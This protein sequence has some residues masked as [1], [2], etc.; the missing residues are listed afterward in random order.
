MTIRLSFATLVPAVFAFCLAPVLHADEAGDKQ[1][2]R[3]V[4]ID[5]ITLAVPEDWK[6]TPPSSNLRK[7]QFEIPAAERDR[8][9]TELVVFFFGG[10]SGTFAQNHERWR[11]EFD[12]RGLRIKLTQGESPQGD[13]VVA[14]LRGTH[15]G[16]AF[17]RRPQPLEDARMLMLVLTVEGK[18][19]YYLKATGPEKTIAS[20]ETSLRTAIGAD[21]EKEK[22]YEAGAR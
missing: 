18:G 7:A 8:E 22:E 4:K 16:S 14:D 11:G 1:K 2:T 12:P 13:Y 20:I 17:A 10:A 9:P 19:P 5:D 21:P 3:E 6:Q 15:V